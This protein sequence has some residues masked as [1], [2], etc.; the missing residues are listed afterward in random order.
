MKSSRL[1]SH[2]VAL[3]TAIL[4]CVSL[5]SLSTAPAWAAAGTITESLS[6]RVRLNSS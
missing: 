2:L 4:A 1:R 6:P 3:L 5:L